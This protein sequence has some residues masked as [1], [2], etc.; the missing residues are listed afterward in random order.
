MSK[1]TKFIILSILILSALAGLWLTELRNMPW[2]SDAPSVSLGEKNPEQKL[3]GIKIV[4][5]D[6]YHKGYAWSDGIESG[7]SHILSQT[8]VELIK[9]R[10]DAKRNPEAES[11]ESNALQIKTRI[12]RIKP[13]VIIASDDHAQKYVIL[14]Y[15]KGGSIPVIFCGV[16]WSADEYGYPATNVTGMIEVD[17]VQSL[18]EHLARYAAGNKVAYV[19]VDDLTERKLFHEHNKRFFHGEMLSFL[20][21]EHTFQSYIET[22]Q[23]A[24][25]KADMI[26][27]SNN[28]GIADWDN[29]KAERFFKENTTKPTGAINKWMTGFA[30]VTFCKL[31]EEQG[32]WSA[33]AALKVLSGVPISE[34]PVE[35]NKKGKLIINLDIAEKLN[36]VFPVDILRNAEVHSKD[37]I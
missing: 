12:D 36:I 14:P 28:A 37:T 32:E 6:S 24:Q 22:F 4:W 23:R 25:T 18:M 9:L 34:I 15:Y 20:A 16:N 10:L 17:L 5:V 8:P 33:S 29:A 30:M 1:Q 21:P 2:Y 7:L 3:T 13:D 35:K 19:A 26:L 11:C 31:P 27:L